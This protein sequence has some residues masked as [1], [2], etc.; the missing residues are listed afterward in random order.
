MF[1]ASA[2][3]STMILGEHAVVYG[4]PAIV[5]AL[6]RRL[7]VSLKPRQDQAV[8]ID[9]ALVQYASTVEK[10]DLHPALSFVLGV[11]RHYP[12]KLKGLELKIESEI[13]HQQGLGSSAAVLIATLKVV[14]AYLNIPFK[15]RA[16]LKTAIEILHEVQGSGSG[17]DLA[18]SLT[19]GL[20]Y[21]DPLTLKI[22]S[23]R[24]YPYIS[25]FYCGYKT[26]TPEVIQ[27][28]Q[29][30]QEAEPDI[31]KSAMAEIE[32]A[33]QAGAEALVEG[34]FITLGEIFE[35]QQAAMVALGLNDPMID[36]LLAQLKQSPWVLG[37]K[38]SGS[39]LGD[40]VISV[41]EDARLPEISAGQRID[42]KIEKQGL[43]C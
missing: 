2:P 40:C 37:A 23:F 30:F 15:P 21:Y 32:D 6:N 22:E 10:L 9:S 13:P 12:G 28:I 20:I 29:A 35:T 16:F 3:A 7:Y 31:F 24:E 18:A 41:N 8:I 42:V 1:K 43:L 14:Q 26:K 36:T 5:A 11:L 39:G 38:I 17:A 25:L 27:K 19:G 34:D 33:V 4:S